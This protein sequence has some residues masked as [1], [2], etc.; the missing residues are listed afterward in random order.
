MDHVSIS[1]Q[2]NTANSDSREKIEG[3]TQALVDNILD[4]PSIPGDKIECKR[5]I[6][7]EWAY[8]LN[9]AL[10]TKQTD[11]FLNFRKTTPNPEDGDPGLNKQGAQKVELI[12]G[13]LNDISLLL[14]KQPPI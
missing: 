9:H 7:Q 3:K 6:G 11:A 13:S 10:S 1:E 8:I 12:K 14:N 4:N 2:L 5:A